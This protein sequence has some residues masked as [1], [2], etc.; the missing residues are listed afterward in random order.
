LDFFIDYFFIKGFLFIILRLIIKVLNKVIFYYLMV[1]FSVLIG[2]KAGDGVKL[3]ANIIARMFNRLGYFVF[4]YEDYPSLIRGGHNFAVIRASDKKITANKEIVDALIALDQETVEKHRFALSK[5][6]VLIFDSDKIKADGFGISLSKIVEESSLPSIVRNV[7]SF[8][9]LAK[10]LGVDFSLVEDCIRSCVSKKVE[11]NIIVAKKGY[12]FVEVKKKIKKLKN[13]P[14]PLITGNDAISL[15]AVKAGLKA[16]VSYPMTPA[17]GIL[18]TLAAN[19]KEFNISVVHPENEIAVALMAEG[20]A[21]AGLKSMVA[22]SGGGFALMTE[23]VSFAGQAEFP[24]V[25]VLSQRPGPATGVPTYSAQGDLFFAIHSG[26]GDFPKIV[27]APS[28]VDQAF[29]LSADA[30][31]LAWKF[32]VPVILLSDKNLSE[33][34]FSASFDENNVDVEK[35]VLWN[36]KGSYKRYSFSVDGVSPLA[37]PGESA[38]VK[39]TSYEH[40]EYGITTEEFKMIVDMMNKR[41]KKKDSIIDFLDKKETVKVFGNEK[42][43]VVVFS[44]GST[45]GVVKEVAE[46]LGIK[47]VQP[48]FLEP[49]P[50]KKIKNFLKGAE[51]VVCV[52]CNASGQ[53]AS[54][55]ACNGFNVDNV[56]LKFDGRP[57]FVD[58]LKDK[59]NGLLK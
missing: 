39:A 46:D 18:H 11:E 30:L 47:A 43:K 17:S 44:W 23:A 10:V 53:L 5:E 28:D 1:D 52:E 24:I 58:E 41:L 48:L 21:Y 19:N 36:K 14:K 33:S 49:F 2:G 9:V 51:K 20:L 55:L 40:D 56:L 54:L 32:Q 45:F 25:F 27:L 6:G 12:E 22:T 7:V 59:I 15:G 35:G 42:S 4:V 8:A 38:V 16:F 13:S 26:H 29:Y 34:T 37:F 50:V 57:F 3:G 31:N